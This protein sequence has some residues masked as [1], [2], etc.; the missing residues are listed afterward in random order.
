M[1]IWTSFI[2]VCRWSPTDPH[3]HV[4]GLIEY[5]SNAYVTFAVSTAQRDDRRRLGNCRRPTVK[6]HV[7]IRRQLY[8]ELLIC[9]VPGANASVS[10]ADSYVADRGEC[11]QSASARRKT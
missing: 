8:V 6:L 11:I 9:R 5:S 1:I 2:N 4:A 3:L 7:D 10:A